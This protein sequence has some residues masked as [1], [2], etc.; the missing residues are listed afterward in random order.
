MS[1]HAQRSVVV[2]ADVGTEPYHVG[3]EAML[4]AN[5]EMLRRHDP[6]VHVTVIGR[7]SAAI[8]EEEAA[9]TLAAAGG[10]F[11]S[12]GGNLS[13]SWPGL[14]HQRLLWLRE[15]RRLCL[16]IVTGGQTIGPELTAIERSALAETLAEVEHFGVRELP[17]AALALQMGLLPDR[18]HYQTDDSFFLAG[19]QPNGAVA[20][21]CPDEP[22]LAI[23]L[24]SAFGAASAAAGLGSL[25][26][27]LA[28]IAGET[29]LHIVF[30]PHVGP[31]GS[32]DGED[33]RVGSALGQR[34]RAKGV[35]C[36]LLPVMPPEE[37]VWLTQQAALVVSSRY[38]PLVFATAGAVP[39]LGL[40]RD[41]YTRIKLQGALAHV[42]QEA[43]CLPATDA[44]EGGLVGAVR[45]LW[46]GREEASATMVRARARIAFHEERRWAR[47]L[48]RLGWLPAFEE[49]SGPLGWPAGQ[50]AV[51]ALAALA[52]E[53]EARED[54]TKPWRAA[55][56]Y[57]ER[58][59]ALAGRSNRPGKRETVEECTVLTEQQW[60][61]YAR[62]G[63]LHLGK[64]LEP[65]ELEALRQR[66]DDLALG[67]VRNLDVQMQLDTGGV[68]EE[69][70]G[71]VSS[72]D[73]GTILYRKI[74]GLE[75]DELF[76]GLVRN[77]L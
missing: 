73:R 39:C 5:L 43:C 41:S 17:S 4:V 61:D 27:Q 10:L 47:L 56:S 53:R 8:Q 38:H 26:A 49:E 12:G 32:L 45:R 68:Y 16:P 55:V 19:R 24:D 69:L 25:A 52:R 51:A 42:G 62:D 21:A 44:E 63:F 58:S 13:S 37:T 66:A 20:S 18:L 28:R 9:A 23:T 35:E 65:V 71:A 77:P 60:N 70:P 11:I 30:V 22:Y 33:G 31:L 72:F 14:L 34:L 59:V 40:Y 76:S 74:Q 54:E 6:A 7:A 50:L 29:G 67:K 1:I 48:A 57:L 75:T 36:T 2:I 64:V 15:A 46:A 3:D